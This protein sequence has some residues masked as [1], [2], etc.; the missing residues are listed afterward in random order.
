MLGNTVSAA[1]YLVGNIGSC[2]AKGI[3]RVSFWILTIEQVGVL[4]FMNLDTLSP[5]PPKPGFGV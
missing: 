2:E 1:S 5:L 4:S 3:R